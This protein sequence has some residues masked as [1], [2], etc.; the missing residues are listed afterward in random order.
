MPD[1]CK[2]VRIVTRHELF[3]QPEREA[4]FESELVDQL[5]PQLGRKG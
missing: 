5:A 1:A 4:S 2:I 3:E